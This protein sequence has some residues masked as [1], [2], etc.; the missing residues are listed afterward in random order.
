MNEKVNIILARYFSGE[1]TKKELHALDSWLSKSDENEKRFYQMILLYQYL[2]QKNI[3][4]NFDIEK[5]LSQFKNYMYE[6]QKNNRQSFFKISTMWKV[7][8]AVA[9]L[10]VVFHFIN[11]PAKTIHLLAKE[12]SEE[13]KLFKNTNV[14]LYYGSEIVYKTKSKQDIQL[15]G[16]AKFA[17]DSKK[18]E[19]IVVQAGETY[20]KNTGT[21]F[22]V[23][24]TYPD[25]F[26]IVD[27]S[28]GE[29]WF[30]TDINKGVHLKS[31]ESIIYDVQKKQFNTEIIF[32]ST[33]LREAIDIIQKR[34]GVEIL[35]NTNALNDVFLNASFN[36]NESVENILEII[37][38]TASAKWTKKNNI[39][40]IVS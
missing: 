37:T 14:T 16:K 23:D 8:A 25:K 4:P 26:I 32:H 29:V 13:Y 2:G 9:I 24:A 1:A 40:Y 31:N 22:T 12:T 36:V 6:K 38:I 39:Y 28:E 33:P 3:V 10:F 35:I 34:Y 18:L 21:V 19:R 11:Q 7:A 15:K 5:A 27:V 30:Y 17:I 20:I